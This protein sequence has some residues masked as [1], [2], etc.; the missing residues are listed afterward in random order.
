[1]LIALLVLALMALL[2]ATSLAPLPLLPPIFWEHMVFALAVLPLITAAMQHFVPVLT[3]GRSVGR[4]L[5]WLPVGLGLVGSGLLL[6]F[7]GVLAWGWIA[8][9]AGLVLLAAA[10]MWVWMRQRAKNALGGAHPG[11]AW[12]VAAML[13]LMLGMAAAAMIPLWP[14]WH[15]Q[16]RQFHLHINLYGFIALTAVGTLQVLFPTATGS[17]DSG[18]S[19]RL[20]QDL[21]WAVLGAVLLALGQTLELLWLSVPGVL[22][23]LWPLGRMALAWLRLDG[24]RVFA[25]HGAAPVLAAAALGLA[26]ALLGVLI[27]GVEGFDSFLVGFMFPLI[28]GAATQLLPIW[29]RPGR[30]TAWH[31]TARAAM[32]RY[33]GVRAL[34]YM[35]SAILPLLGYRCGAMAGLLAL[36]WFVAGLAYWRLND[37]LQGPERADGPQ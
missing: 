19:R 10:W 12:Y 30:Q 5:E 6:V 33:N 31:A 26:L 34:F 1:M 13:C 7:A 18:V 24:L 27:P 22:F 32:G 20:R 16:L 29:L 14:Q 2:I 11:L 28:S 35:T 17:A 25:W 15:L 21:K 4:L 9:L 3:R 37:W 23:W 8:P 36:L